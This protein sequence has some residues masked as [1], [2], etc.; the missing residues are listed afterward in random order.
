MVK[1]RRANYR[2]QTSATGTK[3]GR[4]YSTHVCSYLVL[5]KLGYTFQYL[6]QYLNVCKT[7]KENVCVYK[8]WSST[9][10]RENLW[11]SALLV[12]GAWAVAW[13]T[14]KWCEASSSSTSSKTAPQDATELWKPETESYRFVTVSH[15]IAT[16]TTTAGTTPH[17]TRSK[18]SRQLLSAGHLPWHFHSTLI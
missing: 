17:C 12:G 4:E 13:A 10:R 5:S 15:I 9:R 8:E 14:G 11:V 2:Q 3:Q 7:Y 18:L 6:R 16:I 1:G